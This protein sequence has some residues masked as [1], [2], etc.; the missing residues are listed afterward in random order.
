[1][2]TNQRVNQII[3]ALQMRDEVVNAINPMMKDYVPTIT[4]DQRTT[5]IN[6]LVRL[7]TI[8]A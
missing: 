4:G 6:E 1:M 7:L 8:V 5:L 3:Q 2:D